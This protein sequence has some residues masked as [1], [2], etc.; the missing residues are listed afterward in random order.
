MKWFIVSVGAVAFLVLLMSV[1]TVHES[2]QVVITR[3][4][5]P[6][7]DPIVE[8]GFRLKL[9]IVHDVRRFERRILQWDGDKE[10][11]VTKDQQLIYIDTMARWRI[12]DAKKFL[13]SVQNESRAQT[14]LDDI[15][16]GVVRDVISANNLLEVIRSSNRVM[17]VD[18]ED[19]AGMGEGL[20]VRTVE[21]GRE[22]LMTRM[23]EL[24]A[25]QVVGFGIELIDVRIKRLIYVDR[26]L[27]DLYKRMISERDRIA[28]RFR[29]EGEAERARIQ[30]QLE[31]ELKQ[32]QSDAFR[33]AETIRGGADAEAA[34]V[35]ATAYEA[36]PEFYAFARTL[37]TYQTALTTGDT[38]LLMSSHNELLRFLKLEVLDGG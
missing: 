16:N 30:G 10:Q 6:I 17:E 35:Y 19:D 11:V 8:A 20:K 33:E 1:Y 26:V 3:F 32:L 34:R 2:E 29:S 22:A 25:P 27:Q 24:A 9:P 14:R 28:K 18:I 38:T 13:Q 5:E 36:D 37:D 12:V 7:G 4:G 21:T 15:M 23:F 31:K